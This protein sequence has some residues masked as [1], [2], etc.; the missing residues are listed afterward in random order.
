MDYSTGRPEESERL[1]DALAAVLPASGQ[2]ALEFARAL[3]RKDWEAA[4]TA[5]RLF[6]GTAE[7]S[8]EPPDAW[9][10]LGASLVAHREFDLAQKA[11]AERIALDPAAAKPHDNRAHT[12]LAPDNYTE[13]RQEH[14]W[15]YQMRQARKVPVKDT[16]HMWDGRCLSSKT[17]LFDT[18]QGFG[19]VMQF[20]RFLPFA[21]SR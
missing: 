4:F 3:Q 18:E 12:L 14:E 16:A 10:T 7:K 11:F 1:L 17:L 19:D 2:K 21:A 6:A 9:N 15:R 5:A 13:G 8:G 20:Q